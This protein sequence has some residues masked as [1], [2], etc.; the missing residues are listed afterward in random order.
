MWLN[1]TKNT[2]TR[3]APMPTRTQA[4]MGTCVSLVL[5]SS[6][7]LPLEKAPLALLPVAWPLV[8]DD[9]EGPL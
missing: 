4:Q 5:K 1:E 7:W 9:D 2:A 6:S 3:A 8:D